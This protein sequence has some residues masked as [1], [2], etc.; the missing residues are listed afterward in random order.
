MSKVKK[1]KTYKVTSHQM[2]DI[3]DE[4]NALK[5][6]IGCLHQHGECTVNDLNEAGFLI[7]HLAE[8]FNFRPQA[9]PDPRACQFDDDDNDD[10]DDSETNGDLH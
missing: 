7:P 2:G 10:S 6:M 8:V 4:F 5:R 1:Q 3:L 9:D